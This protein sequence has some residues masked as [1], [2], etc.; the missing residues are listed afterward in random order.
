MQGLLS[1][2]YADPVPRLS[3]NPDCPIEVQ[4]HWAV[5][6]VAPEY[7]RYNADDFQPKKK[8]VVEKKEWTAEEMDQVRGHGRWDLH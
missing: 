8:K 2:Q 1:Q 4:S 6:G 7:T 5:M 3:S